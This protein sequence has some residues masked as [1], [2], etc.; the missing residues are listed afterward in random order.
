MLEILEIILNHK[1]SFIIIKLTFSSRYE[2]KSQE[3]CFKGSLRILDYINVSRSFVR[4]L[5]PLNT[6]CNIVVTSIIMV[7]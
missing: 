1:Y 6:M 4:N 7:R 5:I 3:K 2:A